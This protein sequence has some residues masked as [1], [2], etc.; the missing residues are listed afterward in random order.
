MQLIHRF[1]AKFESAKGGAPFPFINLRMAHHLSAVKNRVSLFY[2][3]LL[4]ISAFQ[5]R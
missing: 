3:K 2:S 5:F 4:H 1:Y